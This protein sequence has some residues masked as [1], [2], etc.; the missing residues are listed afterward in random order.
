MLIRFEINSQSH[1][2]SLVDFDQNTNETCRRIVFI[3]YSI[4]NEGQ[5]I[6]FI[7][8]SISESEIAFAKSLE[9]L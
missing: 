3:A 6:V 2:N 1:I 5:Y 9:K 8:S 4:T 7:K